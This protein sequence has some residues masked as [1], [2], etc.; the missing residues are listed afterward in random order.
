M[1]LGRF[2]TTGSG[3]IGNCYAAPPALFGCNG[4]LSFP[5]TLTETSHFI[6]NIVRVGLNYQFH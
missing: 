6:D 2:T 4:R 1:D 5:A 3:G